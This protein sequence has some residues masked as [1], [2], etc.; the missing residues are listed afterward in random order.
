MLDVTKPRLPVIDL[1]LL[2]HFNGR[3]ADYVLP[4]YLIEEYGRDWS[5]RVNK[6]L[7][8]GYLTFAEPQ[9][10]LN[11]LTMPKLKEILREHGQKLSGKKSQLI[12]RIIETVPLEALQVPKVYALTAVGRHELDSRSFYIENQ[13]MNY[14]F[15]NSEL[16]ELEQDTPPDLILEKL[17][18]RNILKHS[19]DK[20]FA[21]LYLEYFSARKFFKQ[22]GRDDEALTALLKGIYFRL[23]GMQNGNNVGDYQW[24]EYCFNEAF[25]HELDAEKTSRNLSDE[26]LRQLFTHT[27]EPQAVPFSYFDVPTMTDLI[28][29][30]L[31]G[32]EGLLARYAARSRKPNARSRD[33]VYFAPD[34]PSEPIIIQSKAAASSGCLLPCLFVLAVVVA[35]CQ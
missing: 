31:H 32:Q 34:T 7:A 3:R 12:T 27:V 20:D 9:E 21:E 14:G 19:L 15:M 24:L 10:A 30:R 33:Y 25:W 18:A 2:N 17:F 8:N 5:A 4:E 13:Q 22:H 35:F 16:A 28:L 1:L 11:S 23:T 6:L 26:D 29:D